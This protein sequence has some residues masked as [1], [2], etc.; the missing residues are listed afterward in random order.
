MSERF[1]IHLND[2]E[3]LLDSGWI[4]RFP[5]QNVIGRCAVANGC[6]DILHPGHLSLLATLDTVAYQERLRPIVAINSDESVERLKGPGRP[7]VPAS[8]RAMLI[9]SLKWPFTVVIFD[10]DTPQRLMDLLQPAIVVKGSQ[11]PAE[12]V[13]RWKDSKVVSVGMVQ[14]WSTTGILGDTR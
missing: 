9:N 4:S 12:S 6:F 13:V 11:Y 14:G 5:W 2:L 10:E 7:V 1:T 3:E 8:A